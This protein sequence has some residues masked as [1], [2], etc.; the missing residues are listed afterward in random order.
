MRWRNS[1]R[2]TLLFK[3]KLVWKK[4]NVEESYAV[5]DDFEVDESALGLLDP[6]N[7][8]TMRLFN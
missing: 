6:S 7:R 1:F 3:L 5:M 8:M 4:K 2:N